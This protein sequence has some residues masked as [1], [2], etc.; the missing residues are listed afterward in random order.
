[1]RKPD[2]LIGGI[3]FELDYEQHLLR[4]FDKRQICI[5][6][7][8]LTDGEAYRALQPETLPAELKAELNRFHPD[9]PITFPAELLQSREQLIKH[10]NY[11]FNA[12]CLRNGWGIYLVNEP[13][14]QRLAGVLPHIAIA[15]TD[16]TIDVRLKELRETAVPWNALRFADMFDAGENYLFYYRLDS[17]T[18][19]Q[20]NPQLTALPEKVVMIQLPN[21]LLLDPVA[22]AREYKAD[23]PLFLQQNP[24]QGELKA[25]V[26]PLAESALPGIIEQNKKLRQASRQGNNRRRSRGL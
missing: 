22:V 1:M 12:G 21:E 4:Q 7:D 19:Y 5:P 11:E 24:I 23:L 17:H 10:A 14:G 26:K 15:E 9:S 20:P 18:C 6:F 8:S 16:F 25:V 3:P 2:L 13:L